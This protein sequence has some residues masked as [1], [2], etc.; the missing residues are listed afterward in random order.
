MGWV[1]NASPAVDAA[2]NYP[3]IIAVCVCLTAFM[4]TFVGLRVYVRA[5]MLKL[6]G[7]D[8]WIIVFSAVS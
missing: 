2:S 5:V 4:T 8:D 7:I 3:T 1:Q 6:F